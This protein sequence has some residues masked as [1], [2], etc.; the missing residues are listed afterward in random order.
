MKNIFFTAKQKLA[1]WSIAMLSLG[2]A[3][4][5]CSDWLEMPSYTSVD[6]DTAFESEESAELFVMGCYRGLVPSELIYQLAAG[7]TVTHSCED[8]TTNNSKYAI[9]NW[10]F[11]PY[12][13]NTVTT[14]YSEGYSSIEQANIAIR[15]LGKMPE[16][17]KRNQLISEAKAIRAYVYLNLIAYYGDVPAI[18]IP[19]NEMG[20]DEGFYP[21][22]SDRDGIYDQIVADL[23][24]AGTNL[25]WFEESGYTTT[26]RFTKQSALA[27]LA[28]T[29][30]Y[31]GGYSLRWNLETNDPSTLQ[32]KRRDDAARVQEL[33]KIADDACAQIINHG[34]NGL[35]TTQDQTMTNFQYLWYT[36]DQRQFTNLNKEILL[37]LA[38]YGDVTNSKFGLYAHPG[39]R[40]GKYGSRKALQFMLPT[41]YLSFKE[42]DCRRDVTCVPYSIYFLEKGSSDDTW[43]DVGTTYSCIMAGKFRMSWTVGPESDAN[44]RNINIPILRYPDVLLMYAETQAYLNGGTPT[45]EAINAL[46]E[47]RNRAGIGDEPIP[48][49][50]QG[51]EDA[52]V[53]ERKW[54]FGSELNLRTDLI[55]MGRIKKELDATK[56]AMKRLS[57][58]EGEYSDISTLRLYKFHVD[59]QEY[60]DKFMVPEYID[61]T[62]TVETS[63][64]E[65]VPVQETD[66]DADAFQIRKDAYQQELRTIVE[67]HGKTWTQGDIW[68]PC[69]MFEAYNSTFNGQGRKAAGFGQGYNQLQIGNIIYTKPTGYTENGGEFPI[70][71]EASDGSDGLYYGFTE[72]CSELMPFANQ[73]TGHPMVDNPNLTQH[74][75]Y[76]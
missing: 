68:Y 47:I 66:E 14:L 63:I 21:K 61:I 50:A 36:Y 48:T 38:Q 30:L 45:S 42:N 23:Q 34:Y 41:Y 1:I 69:H 19:L 70:W 3:T 29:A 5:S 16:T 62:S 49:D 20:H 26:E 76:E 57:K 43:V 11:D 40:G 9:C 6:Q 13:P 35:I 28:R 32:V 22:R 17:E 56:D 65:N 74:P 10:S 24:E 55:R 44:K 53:Q 2:G 59:A 75:G 54:E 46:Q 4:T 7:E 12:K 58:R 39:T 8:A 27:L 51:F 18:W 72:N 25:P 31:A 67:A 71:I 73:T 33:Y 37:S 15:E 52:L 64:I 60:G